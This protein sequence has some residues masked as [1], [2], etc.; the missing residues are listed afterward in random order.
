M[1]TEQNPPSPPSIPLNERLQIFLT[2]GLAVLNLAA[3]VVLPLVI[4]SQFHPG[5]GVLAAIFAMF[6]W[7]VLGPPPMP[8]FLNGIVALLGMLVITGIMFGCLVRA[9]FLWFS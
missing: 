9:V 8:G 3:C 7:M 1:T 2:F 5:W 6:A 4:A